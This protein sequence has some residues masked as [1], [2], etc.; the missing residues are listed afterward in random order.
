MINGDTDLSKEISSCRECTC[1]GRGLVSM[2]RRL[3]AFEDSVSVDFCVSVCFQGVE[4]KLASS[5]L[6]PFCSDRKNPFDAS[7]VRPSAWKLAASLGLR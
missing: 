7:S 1:P 2:L 6:K 3:N 4:E 5:R